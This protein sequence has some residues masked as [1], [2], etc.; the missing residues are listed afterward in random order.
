MNVPNVDPCTL[1]GRIHTI[2]SPNINLTGNHTRRTW[3]I[4]SL[5]V[6]SP[7]Q[8]QV[9]STIPF[10][11]QRH[12]NSLFLLDITNT[13]LETPIQNLFQQYNDIAFSYLEHSLV[14]GTIPDSI[15][16]DYL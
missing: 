8:S 11:L 14:Y 4:E 7:I 3:S 6:I 9:D 2:R 13:R 12:H 16:A 5:G 1:A 15:G 10:E